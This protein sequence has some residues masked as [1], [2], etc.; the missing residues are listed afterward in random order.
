VIATLAICILAQSGSLYA[1]AFPRPTGHNGYEE[2]MQA[3][4][5]LNSRAYM[6]F[7]AWELSVGRSPGVPTPDGVSANATPLTIKKYEVDR[8]GKALKLLAIGNTKPTFRG[9]SQLGGEPQAFVDLAQLATDAAYVSFA[10]GD[11][12]S[13]TNQLLEVVVLGDNLQRESTFSLEFGSQIAERALESFDRQ[14]TRWSVKDCERIALRV[15]SILARPNAIGV[16]LDHDLAAVIP[17]LESMTTGTM[18]LSEDN[19]GT[20]IGKECIR[21][22][23]A[24]GPS[25]RI[26]LKELVDH[27]LSMIYGAMQSR[28]QGPESQW[29]AEQALPTETELS[30]PLTSMNDLARAVCLDGEPQ[31]NS[32]SAALRIRAQ[33]RILRLHARIQAYKWRNGRLPNALS[34]AATNLEIQD[35]LSGK[36]FLFEIQKDMTYRIYSDG[37]QSTGQIDL[38]FLPKDGKS[39]SPLQNA[40]TPVSQGINVAP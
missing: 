15:E 9:S 32:L 4:D 2:Y 28:F 36:P 38:T 1:K 26:Q 22:L 27:R 39:S 31:Y 40:P 14:K 35:P 8:F 33:L 37:N 18:K 6:E 25:E 7:K 21:R 30:L 3:A 19:A 12:S 23:N 16:A 11:W 5:I 34:D 24:L 29:S 10:K 17:N 13:G 20:D